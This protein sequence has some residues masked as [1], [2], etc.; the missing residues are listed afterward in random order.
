M[1]ALSG[2]GLSQGLMG[3]AVD[4][5]RQTVLLDTDLIVFHDGAVDLLQVPPDKFRWDSDF[6]CAVFP[7]GIDSTDLDIGSR[8]RLLGIMTGFYFR[9]DE[10][11]REG[12]E[13]AIEDLEQLWNNAL[14][15]NE[16]LVWKTSFPAP[17]PGFGA[18]VNE[19]I[20]RRVER[21]LPS[22][23]GNF[24]EPACERTAEFTAIYPIRF[25]NC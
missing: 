17:P 22:L 24:A 8:E 14:Y 4:T 19:P 15:S 23:Y 5:W 12:G 9:E 20:A 1:S 7:I 13:A 2:K 6:A 18:S 25:T 10:E 3:A 11:T 16:Q 21:Q